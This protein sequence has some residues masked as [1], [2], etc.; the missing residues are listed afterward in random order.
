[1]SNTEFDCSLFVQHSLWH[2][3]EHAVCLL[4]DVE[5]NDVKDLA[6]YL[7]IFVY[8]LVDLSR[9]LDIKDIKRLKSIKLRTIGRDDG[10][11]V[12]SRTVYIRIIVVVTLSVQ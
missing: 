1:M 4:V 6:K 7:G 3:K 8:V 12:T 10:A 9:K 2:L 11:D 5:K